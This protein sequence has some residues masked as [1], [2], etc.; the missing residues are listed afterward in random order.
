MAGYVVPTNYFAM[1][2]DEILATYGHEVSVGRKTLHKFGRFENVGTSEADINYLGIDPLHAATNS[3]TTVSSSNN[4]DTTQSLTVEGMTIDGSNNLSF[5]L[6]T[7]ALNG[8]AK[9][10]L[11]TPL[12]RVTRIASLLGPVATL[13]DVYAYQDGAITGGIPNDLATVDN[14]M[15]ASDQSTLFA[16]T[17]VSS[18][19]YFVLTNYWSYLGK[20]TT[21][22]ADI[23]F[24]TQKV[25]TGFYRTRSVGNITNSSGLVRPQAPFLIIE[26]NSDI[27]ITAVG[28]TT[29]VDVFAGF[30]GFFADIIA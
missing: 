24:K 27:D 21:A 1:A 14:V 19:N 26:P 12:S 20:K 23:R 18:T 13:G 22:L 28:S 9:V 7:V 6:Q 16:G 15:A 11:A 4:A 30:E 29:N 10:A 2:R 17:S 25:G 5:V 3:I 8:Q